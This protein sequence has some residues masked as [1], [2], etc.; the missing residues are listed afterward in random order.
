MFT[1]SLLSECDL[2]LDSENDSV[3]IQTVSIHSLLSFTTK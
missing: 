1:S 3:F 2:V